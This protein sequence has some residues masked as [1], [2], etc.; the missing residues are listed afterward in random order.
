MRF[1]TAALYFLVASFIFFV[2]FAVSFFLITEVNDALDPFDVGYGSTYDNLITLIPSAFG[3][4]AA[5][6]FISGILL[7]FILDSLADEPEMYFRR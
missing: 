6:F 3:I 1:P 7:I 5:I 4:I 2:F